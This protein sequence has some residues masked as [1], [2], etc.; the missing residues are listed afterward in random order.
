[1]EKYVKR[2]D[3]FPAKARIARIS[4]EESPLLDE[5]IP[6]FEPPIKEEPKPEPTE[7]KIIESSGNFEQI[8]LF[9]DLNDDE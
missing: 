6:S 4:I 8:S 5:T 2:P 7:D 9:D 1:M 3:S